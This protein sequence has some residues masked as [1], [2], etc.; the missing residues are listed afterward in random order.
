M[1][2]FLVSAARAVYLKPTAIPAR[3]RKAGKAVAKGNGG[4]VKKAK[5]GKA[6]RKI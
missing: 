4:A 5:G 6:K 3:A 1:A 2:D